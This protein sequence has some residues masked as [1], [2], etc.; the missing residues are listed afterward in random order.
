MSIEWIY[1]CI[2]ITPQQ[3]NIPYLGRNYLTEVGKLP[4][5][6]ISDILQTYNQNKDRFSGGNVVCEIP[7]DYLEKRKNGIRE[8]DGKGNKVL[9]W[10]GVH[11]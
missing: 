10:S 9:K 8:Y 6:K 5:S 7:S 4:I 2:R 1:F 3:S 11:R